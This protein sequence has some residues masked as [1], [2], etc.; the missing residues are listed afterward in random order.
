MTTWPDI[1]DDVIDWFRAAFAKANCK[2]TERLVNIPNI[3][4]TTLDDGL[5]DALIPYS[6][7]QLLPSGAVVEMSIHNIGGLRRLGSWETADIAVLV[8]VYRAGTLLSQKIGF[9]QSK[10]LYPANN[11]VEDDDPVGFAYGMNAFLRRDPKSPLGKLYRQF[12]FTSDCSYGALTAG[13]DQVEIIQRLN[14]EFGD[15]VYYLFYNPPTIPATVRYPVTSYQAVTHPPLGCRVYTM[16][17]VEPLL[18]MLDEGVAPTI[19]ALEKAG[20][21]SNWRLETWAADLLLRCKVGQQFG[22]DRREMVG[23]LLTRRSG[24]IAAA[25]AVSIELGGDRP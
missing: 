24:P 14:E 5:I 17:D 8:F 18:S 23:R 9:L 25:I 16:A 20:P 13:S 6:P 4:E 21:A 3:R 7:P 22:E 12:E 2:V 10:R 11:D 1:P 15:A 19:G